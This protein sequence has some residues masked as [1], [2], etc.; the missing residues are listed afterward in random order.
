MSIRLIVPRTEATGYLL[1]HI[2]D[3]SCVCKDGDSLR[4]DRCVTI[5]PTNLVVACL[6]CGFSRCH[7]YNIVFSIN[8]RIRRGH[9][10]TSPV[11]VCFPLA[12]ITPT[13]KP[14]Q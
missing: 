2:L 10:P 7:N 14:P 5:L 1:P 13:Y 6:C 11:E 9:S 3:L 4:I 12:V 8:S